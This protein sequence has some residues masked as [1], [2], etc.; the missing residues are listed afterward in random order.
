MCAAPISGRGP[1]TGIACPTGHS[2][3]MNPEN[4]L[5]LV[6]HGETEWSR[7]ARHTGRTDVPLT[8]VGDVQARALAPVL[9]DRSA[10]HVLVSPAVRSRR[11]A[12][13]AGFAAAEVEP[14]LWEWDYGGGGG[15][16]SAGVRPRWAEWGPFRPGIGS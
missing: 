3:G 5:V 6:R 15:G 7:A 13:L 2:G 16:T 4:E 12:Q 11:T 9:S 8:A 14:G 1:F 10:A